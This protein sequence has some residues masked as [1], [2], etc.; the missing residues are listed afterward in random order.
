MRSIVIGDLFRGLPD[1]GVTTLRFNF[2]GVEG[3]TGTWDEGTGE[4]G[5]VRAALDALVR[6]LD[7]A[8]PIVLMGWSFGADMALSVHDTRL[9]AW[10]L[11]APPMHFAHDTDAI[12]TDPRPKRIVLG[13]RDE[14]VMLD[15]VRDATQHWVNCKVDVIRGATH[16]FV[17]C[18]DAVVAAAV[19]LVDQVAG[20]G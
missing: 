3:S 6:R 10:L 20:S 15:A 13:D 2:R 1:A 14:V 12:A 17:G 7:D 9:A 16:F 8:V 19:E 11:I 4:R 18:G 5:D